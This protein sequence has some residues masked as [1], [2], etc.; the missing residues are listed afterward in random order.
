MLFNKTDF[1]KTTR[2][3]TTLWYSG[4]FFVLEI[5]S[6]LII[7][8]HLHNSMLNDLDF[9]LSNQAQA[10]YKFVSESNVD[11]MDFQSDSVYTSKEDFVY[12]L[13]FDALVLNPRNAF[14][15]VKFNNNL[16]FQSD[17]LKKHQIILNTKNSRPIN[18][19]DFNDS[20]LSDHILRGAL[21]KKNKY[22]IIVAF[23]TYLISETLGNLTDLNI[24]IG[25]IFLVLAVI[26]GAI[27]SSKSL[28]RIDSIINKTKEITAQNLDEKIPGGD[29]DDEYGRLV[30]TMNDM[31]LRIKTAIDYMNQ[32]S[33]AASHELKTPLTILRGEIEIALKSPK[34][35]DTYRQVLQSNYEETLR[36]INIV[37]KLFF[38]SKVD[39]SLLKL[40]KEK[41]SI[42]KLIELSINQ[43]QPFAETKK[44]KIVH[45]LNNDFD[46]F[47]DIDLMR[48]AVN[49]LIE[50]A[51]KYGNDN[52]NIIIACS[53]EKPDEAI[54][55]IANQGESIPKEFH[56]K[57]FER[58]FRLES[59]RSRETG[60]IGLGLSI[61]RSIVEF[62]KGA[63]KVSS[64]I[65]KETRFSIYL[66]TKEI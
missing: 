50:N 40:K 66:N 38:L 20:F 13:I 55:S 52:T 36:L 65:G 19:T 39:H 31:I 1:F 23:P 42:A 7:Y 57:I 29:Y 18:L 41:T 5:V 25:P 32:F 51:I 34:P 2:F 54:I 4:L 26:G 17:N 58:F 46:L 24:I 35:A 48:R 12:D 11:L 16:L 43:M 37:D 15:Q 10:I 64:E 59:S 33:I 49:N 8:F 56:E 61:V 28:S 45:I 30:R 60:G 44:M 14:I 47:V 9:S 21:L 62:H 63:I 27:I 3:K 22:E 53:L 6:G